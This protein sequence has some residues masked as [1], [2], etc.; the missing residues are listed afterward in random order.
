MYCRG[1]RGATTVEGNN[2]EAILNATR[3]LLDALIAANGLREE[4]VVS[5]IFSA[6]SDLDAVFP[7]KAARDL[8]WA[9][10]ALFCCQEMDV[11]DA[12]PKCIR[13]LIHWNTPKSQREVVHV[14]LHGAR[15]LRPDRDQ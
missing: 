4:D 13:V 2:A 6:T 1:I 9:D 14:Y 11:P 15:I 10:T 5:A 3:E 7:A 12:P 8:G